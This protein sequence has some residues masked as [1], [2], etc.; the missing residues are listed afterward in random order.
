MAKPRTYSSLTK[1]AATL[2]GKKIILGRKQ[3][4]WTE[5]NLADRAGITRG[6]LQKI[7]RGE[8]GCAI[9]SVF[10]VAVLVGVNLFDHPVHSLEEQIQTAQDKIALLPMRESPIK[11]DVDDEF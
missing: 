2:L 8:L 1:Q 9:G 5:Q 7:Q 6:T 4:H 10:E 3:R 11:R